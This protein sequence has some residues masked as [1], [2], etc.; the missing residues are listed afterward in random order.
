[1]LVEEPA[2]PEISRQSRRQD[3]AGM[4]NRVIVIELHRKPFKGKR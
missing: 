1:V 2:Q 3:E 4:G